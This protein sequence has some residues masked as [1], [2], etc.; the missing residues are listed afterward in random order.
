[1]IVCLK[2]LLILKLWNDVFANEWEAKQVVV[3]YVS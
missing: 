1:M 3:S 2:N